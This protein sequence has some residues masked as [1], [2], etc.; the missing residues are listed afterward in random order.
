MNEFVESISEQIPVQ[1]PAF[2][3]MPRNGIVGSYSNSTFN[4]FG[5][6]T[7]CFT[8]WLHHFTFPP[9]NKGSVKSLILK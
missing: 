8:L 1:V 4:F 3:C 9:V 7:Y 2:E 6:S 5:Q